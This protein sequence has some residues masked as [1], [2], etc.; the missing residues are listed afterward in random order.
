MHT[1]KASKTFHQ[2]TSPWIIGLL[3]RMIKAAVDFLK[4]AN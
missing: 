1:D 3:Q 2:H 4:Q